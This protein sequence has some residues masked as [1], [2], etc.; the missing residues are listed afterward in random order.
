MP[1]LAFFAGALAALATVTTAIPSPKIN[2][3]RYPPA[4]RGSLSNYTGDLAGDSFVSFKSDSD[5]TS[6]VAPKQNVWGTLSIDEA[7]DI[8]SFLHGTDLNLTSTQDAGTWDNYINVI[9]LMPPNKSDVVSFL[10]GEG[11][12]PPRYAI[13]S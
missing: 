2:S 10:D 1:R 4:Y 13:V 9:D 3:V 7:A 8:V 11:S 5:E 6:V 12:K